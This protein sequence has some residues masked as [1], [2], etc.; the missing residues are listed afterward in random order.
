MSA[1]MH[2]CT[3][4]AGRRVCSNAGAQPQVSLVHHLLA[5]LPGVTRVDVNVLS[6][7]V[8][9]RHRTGVG[10]GHCTSSADLL[11]ALCGAKL[12]VSFDTKESLVARCPPLGGGGAKRMW[13]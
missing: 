4:N 6:K 3:R 2:E 7:S 13:K 1:V 8:V 5:P 12:Q 11:D 9:V 10:E